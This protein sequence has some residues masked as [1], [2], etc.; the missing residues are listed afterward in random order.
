MKK[1]RWGIVSTGNIANQ[2]AQGIEQVEGAKVEAVL[3]RSMS[4][5]KAFAE[6]YGSDR[7][8]DSYDKMINDGNLDAIYIGTPNHMHY[9]D[10]MIFLEAGFN[11]VCEKPLAGNVKQVEEIIAKAKEKN[12]FFLEG[13][14]TRFFPTIKQSLKWIEEGK[15]GDPTMVHANFGINTLSDRDAWRYSKDAC[16]GA[17]VDVGIY[18]LCMIFGV[19]GS[20]YSE[21]FAAG[22]VENGIDI[23]NSFTLKYENDK[24]GMGSSAFSAIY[25]NKVVISG[26]KGN[27]IIGEGFNWWQ[28][29]KAEL[30]LTNPTDIVKSTGGYEVFEDD[31]PS[32]GFQYEAKAVQDYIL[33]GKKQ[34]DEYTWKESIKVA[35]TMDMMRGKI[36]V[37]YDV[38]GE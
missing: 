13:M 7:C 28:A 4:N 27:I 26:P 33:A 30:R 10:C 16:G 35:K 11:V 18:P 21:F 15:I 29:K 1:F 5:A 37:I 9:S 14:W 36:G 32:T 6:R 24:I 17:L 8:Y 23:Y 34:A 2:F 20:Q 31:Y 3:S 38:D 19:Y 22:H 12:V 25:D